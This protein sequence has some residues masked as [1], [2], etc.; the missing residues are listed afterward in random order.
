M[1]SNGST[2]APRGRQGTEGSGRFHRQHVRAASG[3]DSP[4]ALDLRF[5]IGIL[6]VSED[7]AA[8]TAD[9]LQ[10]LHDDLCPA[11]SVEAQFSTT[12]SGAVA[13]SRR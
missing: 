8:E 7:K 12:N 3:D 6:L 5:H 10:P 1:T 2:G 11:Q 9:E 13:R 4:T